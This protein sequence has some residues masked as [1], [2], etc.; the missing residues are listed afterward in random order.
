MRPFWS[1]YV[2]GFSRHA[3]GLPD[4]TPASSRPEAGV[5][6]ARRAALLLPTLTLVNGGWPFGRNGTPNLQ[7]YLIILERSDGCTI[8]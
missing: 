2:I 7:L 6:A 3:N 4:G 8:F 1:F 5:P